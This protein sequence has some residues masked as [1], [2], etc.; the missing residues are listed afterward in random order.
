[1]SFDFDSI[2][3]EERKLLMDDALFD[4]MGYKSA[5]SVTSESIFGGDEIEAPRAHSLPLPQYR[6]LSVLSFSR[7]HSPVK[8]DD[9]MIV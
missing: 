2:M 6:K 4:K 7:P 8:E 3:D 1:M 9:T 5:S